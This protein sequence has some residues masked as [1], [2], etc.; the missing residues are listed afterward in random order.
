MNDFDKFKGNIEKLKIPS[1]L[2]AE[3]VHLASLYLKGKDGSEGTFYT[4]DR[5]EQ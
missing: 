5:W 2:K 3:I 1:K 4:P